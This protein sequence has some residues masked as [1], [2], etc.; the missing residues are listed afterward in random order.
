MRGLSAWSCSI[1][2]CAFAYVNIRQHTSAYVS[3]RQH[4][5]AYVSIRQHTDCGLLGELSSLA[6]AVL[7]GFGLLGL[8]QNDAAMLS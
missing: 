6:C 2:R 8:A 3:I 4:T 7:S 1:L 5:S